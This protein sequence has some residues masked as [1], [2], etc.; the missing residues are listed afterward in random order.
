MSLNN[1]DSSAKACNEFFTQLSTKNLLDYGCVIPVSDIHNMLGIT[2]PET[3][4]QDIFKELELFEL[5]MIDY[6]RR[7]LLK[8]GKYFGKDGAAYRVY[9]PSENAKKISNFMAAADRR[10][11]K[12]RTLLRST[13]ASEF[14]V[15]DNTAVRIQAKRDHIKAATERTSI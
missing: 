3:G 1:Y 2:V 13:P 12:A 9:L 8:H 4:T 14:A 7:H 10:L 5:N 15:N 6:V 11:R